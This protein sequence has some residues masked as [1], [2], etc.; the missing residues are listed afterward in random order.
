VKNNQSLIGHQKCKKTF[1]EMKALIAAD[2]MCV[3]PNHN[4]PYH[5]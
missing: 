1:D 2:V 3:Y 5:I 4:K